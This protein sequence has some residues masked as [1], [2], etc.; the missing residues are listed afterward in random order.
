[1]DLHNASATTPQPI[2]SPAPVP[3]EQ[4]VDGIR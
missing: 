2:Y 4:F 3:V 1:M